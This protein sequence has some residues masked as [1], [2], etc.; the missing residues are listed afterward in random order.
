M[1]VRQVLLGAVVAL[2]VL[3]VPSA[4]T[5][6]TTDGARMTGAVWLDMD[7]DGTRDAGEPGRGDVQV[8]LRT[9]ASILDATMTAADGSWSFASVQ[10]GTYDVLVEAP[11]DHV[12]TGGTLPELDTATGR[13]TV[14]VGAEDI[15]EVGAIGLGS[16]VSSGPDVATTVI[17]DSGRSD[18]DRF[19]WIVT[20]H[21]IGPADVE[22]PVD[23]RIVLSPDHETVE[24]VGEGWTCE[25]S[26]AI[27][28][29]E[30]DAGIPAAT[31][32]PAITMTTSPVGDVGA[33]VSVTGTARLDGVFDAAPLNDEDSATASIGASGIAEDI[34]G[35]G[36]G[37]LTEAG[38]STTGLLV[39][40]LLALVVG[41]GA[42][43]TSRRTTHRP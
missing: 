9:S 40:A 43:R 38:A 8:T 39:A 13:G 14:T 1:R 19:R 2:V 32:L 28:L 21:N 3:G 33:S 12:V 31:S 37:D 23:L 11:I 7:G 42:V 27:V 41:A 6:S 16:P 24:V 34:D 30:T 29:C 17:H 10:P 20:A 15:D 4:A 35:D 26:A 25:P 36:T 18:D 5:A 22:G